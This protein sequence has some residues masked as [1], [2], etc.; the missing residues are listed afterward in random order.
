MR[1]FLLQLPVARLLCHT[2]PSFLD[3]LTVGLNRVFYALVPEGG[4]G[5]DEYF[6]GAAFF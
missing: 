5:F 6:V 2:G 4:V 3:G 1:F